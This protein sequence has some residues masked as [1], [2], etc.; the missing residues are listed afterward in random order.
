MP[1]Q[2]MT[3]LAE[4]P[5]AGALDRLSQ[6]EENLAVEESFDGSVYERSQ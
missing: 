2:S 6:L 3:P 5:L 4:R 1:H